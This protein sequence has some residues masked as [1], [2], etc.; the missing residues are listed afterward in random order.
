MN[1]SSKTLLVVA[2]TLLC[3][4]AALADMEGAALKAAFL[5]KDKTK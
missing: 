5:S 2:L 4:H 3:T 1:I